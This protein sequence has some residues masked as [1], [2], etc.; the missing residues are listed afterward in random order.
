M[1]CP[2][3]LD[4]LVATLM[5]VLDVCVGRDVGE[6]PRGAFLMF[7]STSLSFLPP[8][9]LTLSVFLFSLP[10]PC[11]WF[12]S[13][14]SPPPPSLLLTSFAMPTSF[15]SATPF[16]LPLPAVDCGRCDFKLQVTR[17]FYVYILKGKKARHTHVRQ[18]KIRLWT[19]GPL[20]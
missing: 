4:G 1:M 11:P 20:Q 9:L 14:P 19:N 16:L 5:L 2:R 7:V 17:R 6:W 13:H 15:G 8:T 12:L 3:S 10:F 18:S